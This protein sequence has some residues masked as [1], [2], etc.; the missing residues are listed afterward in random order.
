ME[1][2]G[3]ILIALFLMACGVVVAALATAMTVVAITD[4]TAATLAAI[5]LAVATTATVRSS[6]VAWKRRKGPLLSSL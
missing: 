1:K 3:I 4:D 2:F 5:P 6:L